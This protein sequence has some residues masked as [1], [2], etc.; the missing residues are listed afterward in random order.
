MSV[1]KDRDDVALILDGFL[2]EGFLPFQICDLSVR[3]PRAE[4]GGEGD[5]LVLGSIRLFYLPRVL[6]TLCA[7]FVD[8]NEDGLQVFEVEQ[9]VVYQVTYL[10][11]VRLSY[12]CREAN[13]VQPAQRMVGGEDKSPARR[14]RPAHFQRQIEIADERLH[15]VH[16]VQVVVARQDIVQFLLVYGTDQSGPFA[17][18]LA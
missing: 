10:S 2:D 15:E 17:V 9:K 7:V 5:D 8:G 13:P 6:L 4:P 1:E 14:Y 11:A 16:P 18:T 12:Q 3:P